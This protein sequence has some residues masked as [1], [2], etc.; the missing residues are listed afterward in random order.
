MTGKVMAGAALAVVLGWA[1]AAVAAPLATDANGMAG[2][3]GQVAFVAWTPVFAGGEV[4][5][6]ITIEYSVYAPGDFAKSFPG[7][8]PSSDSEYVYAVQIWNDLNPYPEPAPYYDDRKGHVNTLTIG[9]NGGDEDVSYI[10]Y[11]DDTT[12]VGNAPTTMN[13]NPSSVLWD[14][15]GPTDPQLNYDQRSDI[16]IFTSPHG[17]EWDTASASGVWPDTQSLPSPTHEPGTM[18]LLGF[19]VFFLT[20]KRHCM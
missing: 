17:P 5:F 8:D 2:F 12:V 3:K 18:L 16:L 15:P 11:V 14:F 9:L 10:G 4:D 19:G 7:A 20:R 6:A 13:I 1:G